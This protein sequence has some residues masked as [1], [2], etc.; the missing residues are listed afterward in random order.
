MELE[1]QIE[2]LAVQHKKLEEIIASELNQ[3]GWDE[4]R[5]AALKKQKL[6]IKDELERLKSLH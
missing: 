6:R 2:N 3:P 4:S 5:I 1:G